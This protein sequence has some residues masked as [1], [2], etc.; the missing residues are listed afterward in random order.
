M[1]WT[2]QRRDADGVFYS[3]HYCGLDG[4][5]HTENGFGCRADAQDAVDD[6][7][8]ELDQAELDQ[9][10]LGQAAF[11]RAGFEQVGDGRTPRQG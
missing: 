10:E 11:D 5:I 1:G 4:R 6:A 3:A 2:R 9:P 7:E 8:A